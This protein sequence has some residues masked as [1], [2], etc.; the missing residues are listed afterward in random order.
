MFIN[1][2]II[3]SDN[4]KITVQVPCIWTR[5]S[6]ARSRHPTSCQWWNLSDP[7][8]SHIASPHKLYFKDRASVPLQSLATI[9][10]YAR[11]S[12]IL[13]YFEAGFYVK[14]GLITSYNQQ[15]H[16]HSLLKPTR[17][18]NR[19]FGQIRRRKVEEDSSLRSTQQRKSYDIYWDKQT[20]PDIRQEWGWHGQTTRKTNLP[21]FLEGSTCIIITIISHHVI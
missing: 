12:Y 10:Y 5:L 1:I 13:L 14:S 15:I 2:S 3:H 20:R 19:P 9:L 18:D 11:S 16:G 6:E 17:Q 21:H 8:E 7:P 4:L